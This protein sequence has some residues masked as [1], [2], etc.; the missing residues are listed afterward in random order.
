MTKSEVVTQR[1]METEELHSAK[2]ARNGRQTAT[3][4]SFQTTFPQ[5]FGVPSAAD[6]KVD[7]ALL[8]NY[9]MWNSGDGRTGL[10][11]VLTEGFAE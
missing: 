8:K 5:Q 7:F 9:T 2:V 10:R 3:V 1:D 4:A 6:S 11:F